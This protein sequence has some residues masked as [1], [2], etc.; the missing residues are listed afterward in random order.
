MYFQMLENEGIP[1]GIPRHRTYAEVESYVSDLLSVQDSKVQNQPNAIHDQQ[2]GEMQLAALTAMRAVTHHF[3]SPEFRQGPF[4]YTLTDL[5]QNNIYVDE[6]WNIQTV[7]DLEW[8]HSMPIEMQLPPYWLTSRA[9]D[10]FYDAAGVAEYEAVLEQYLA[11]YAEEERQRDCRGLVVEANVQRAVWKRGSFWYFQALLI[12]KG[13]YTI[14]NRHVQ[15]LFNK[16]HADLKIFDEVFFW[17]W[18]LRV[19]ALIDR[20]LE[21]KQVYTK[22]VNEAW[23]RAGGTWQISEP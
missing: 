18:G 16:D 3:I 20:K 14:F 5:Q 17:Y 21:D 23:Q 7:I 22:R 10:Q 8:A 19:Q 4:V 9:V 2:D 6:D 15:P 13:M 12:P 11:V 1:T